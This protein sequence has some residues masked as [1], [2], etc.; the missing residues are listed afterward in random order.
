MLREAHRKLRNAPQEETERTAVR[1]PGAGVRNSAVFRGRSASTGDATRGFS[2]CLTFWYFWVKPKVRRKTVCM[3]LRRH[4]AARAEASASGGQPQGRALRRL[5]PAFLTKNLFLALSFEERAKEDREAKIV[6]KSPRTTLNDHE[7]LCF[8][9]AKRRAAS[10]VAARQSPQ[11]ASALACGRRSHDRSGRSVCGG[12]CFRHFHIAGSRRPAACHRIINNSNWN[13]C[14]AK[15]TTA[16][17]MHRRRKQ[18]GRRFEHPE[19]VCERRQQASAEAACGLCRAATVEAARLFAPQKRSLS[20]P[21][22]ENRR[23]IPT[24]VPCGHFWRHLLVTKGGKT[25]SLRRICG[26]PAC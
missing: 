7:R 19:R 11:A 14:C 20:C 9:G 5:R 16:S 22:S 23:P 4:S 10:T 18:S 8:C 2:P 24:K 26:L 21:L 17:A 15:R 3:G 6:G 25:T 12:F 13:H 1:T